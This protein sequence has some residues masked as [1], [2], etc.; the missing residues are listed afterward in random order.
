MFP[1]ADETSPLIDWQDGQPVSRRFGDVYFSRDSGLEETRHV[2]LEGNR[3]RERWAALAAARP[4]HDRRNRFRHRPQFRR[5]V[6]A[7]GRGW[8]PPARGSATSASSA[9]RSPPPTSRARS[10][11]GRSSL[12]TAR[13]LLAQWSELAPGWHRFVFGGGRVLLTLLAGDVRTVLPRLDG[14]VDAWFLDGFAPAKNP[15]MWRAGRARPGRAPVRPGRDLRDLHRCRRG[16]ARA[17]S[18]RLRGRED[19]RVRAQARDAA[20]RRCARRRPRALARP[21]VRS[22]GAAR[23]GARRRS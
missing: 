22:P 20:R 10:A 5:R 11:C 16:P 12:A 13:Q 15:E 6:G 14:R 3:L 18:R 23:R 8:L 17:R 1:A 9:T 7:L 4:L 2:F 19:A 21:V